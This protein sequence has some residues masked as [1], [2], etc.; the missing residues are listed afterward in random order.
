MLAD[1][2]IASLNHRIEQF[3]SGNTAPIRQSKALGELVSLVHLDAILRDG[4]S[5]QLIQLAGR[6]H[7]YRAKARSSGNDSAE[8]RCAA[9]LISR[10]IDSIIGLEYDK[11]YFAFLAIEYLTRVG[12]ST[13]E[14]MRQA[15]ID[16]ATDVSDL[17]YDIHPD[18][19]ALLKCLAQAY[20]SRYAL[21]GHGHDLDEAIN[22]AR[23]SLGLIPDGQPQ[24][25]VVRKILA[26]LLRTRLEERGQ[27]QDSEE[28]TSIQPGPVR[29]T[30]SSKALPDF[31]Y[32]LRSLSVD[33]TSFKSLIER[34]TT[35]PLAEELASH[36]GET[37]AGDL[38]VD[39]AM[40]RLDIPMLVG[41]LVESGYS[42][43]LA[44]R[45]EG[46]AAESVVF[47][48][49]FI[50]APLR[51][52][53]IGL[54]S[55]PNIRGL[56]EKL[57]TSEAGRR[58]S[59]SLLCQKWDWASQIFVDLVIDESTEQTLRAIAHSEGGRELAGLLGE[60][61]AGAS[62]LREMIGDQRF[63]MLGREL[64]D[65]GPSRRFLADLCGSPAMER[66]VDDLLA[67]DDAEELLTGVLQSR[68]VADVLAPLADGE[69]L[70]Q[71]HDAITD[72]TRR[73]SL[74]DRLTAPITGRGDASAEQADIAA[75]LL[76]TLIAPVL[77]TWLAS[78][79]VAATVEVVYIA[80]VIAVTERVDTAGDRDDGSQSDDELWI[81]LSTHQRPLED[82]DRWRRL[83]G[84]RLSDGIPAVDASD[85]DHPE[86]LAGA[87]YR[88][89]ATKDLIHPAPTYQDRILIQLANAWYLAYRDENEAQ[90]VIDFRSK[91]R[92]EADEHPVNLKTLQEAIRAAIE[93]TA[94]DRWKRRVEDILINL[95]ATGIVAVISY[96]VA[97][98]MELAP[99]AD[100]QVYEID[101]GLAQNIDRWRS[102]ANSD[103]P[104]DNQWTSDDELALIF[105][106]HAL[107]IAVIS[108]AY[109]QRYIQRDETGG[110]EVVTPALRLNPEL[111]AVYAQNLGADIFYI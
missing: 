30:P 56:W 85:L 77:A 24:K 107:S 109:K 104:T 79:G 94:R 48:F 25:S 62:F 96:V 42:D 66:L 26:S 67:R 11:H 49:P 28:L 32:D 105:S 57:A 73:S 65:S 19:P 7:F 17:L 92:N 68:Y 35:F 101:L 20:K 110:P 64:L 70:G 5:P 111:L 84:A 16:F 14:P 97:R 18:R 2:T 60:T 23:S 53:N 15:A 99:S 31:K 83:I 69:E 12:S 55:S 95:V 58:L 43:V 106:L 82:S 29:W 86:Q 47:S 108:G 22:R 98:L 34:S 81:P 41:I 87:V 51:I 50:G 78:I 27:K 75:L 8:F 80:A 63:V 54:A 10:N 100:A 37:K 103:S 36:L 39:S 13:N 52:L 102:K 1:A 93:E 21:L 89:M 38:V 44:I 88:Y 71:L 74:A 9:S 33:A 3:E 40:R 6:F 91:D 90:S 72:S 4:M 46:S 61:E 45:L 59:S 76:P